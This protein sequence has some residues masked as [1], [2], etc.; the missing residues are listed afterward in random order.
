MPTTDL[1]PDIAAIRLRAQALATAAGQPVI[2]T[3]LAP[4]S[5]AEITVSITKQP[6]GMHAIR[7]AADLQP[8]PGGA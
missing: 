5:G 1:T 6:D 3:W 7:P 4:H 2:E 8:A